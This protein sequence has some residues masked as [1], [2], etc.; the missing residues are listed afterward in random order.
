MMKVSDSVEALVDSLVVS[1]SAGN[2]VEAAKVTTAL[3]TMIPVAAS[4]I[5]IAM[6]QRRQ[7]IGRDM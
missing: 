3:P 1:L 7:K 4:I 6:T 5:S 2:L